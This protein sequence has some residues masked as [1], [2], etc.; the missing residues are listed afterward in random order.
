[1]ICDD[2]WNPSHAH[3]V[4]RQLAFDGAKGPLFSAAFGHGTWDMGRV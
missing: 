2:F 4:F 1:M 3:V